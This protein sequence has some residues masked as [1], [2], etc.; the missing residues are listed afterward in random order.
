MLD[1]FSNS[2]KLSQYKCV[3]MSKTG[4]VLLSL[5]LYYS[6]I[7]TNAGTLLLGYFSDNRIKDYN[8][9]MKKFIRAPRL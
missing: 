1:E 4:Y 3:A 5:S 2:V 7:L 6:I 8:Y 9:H